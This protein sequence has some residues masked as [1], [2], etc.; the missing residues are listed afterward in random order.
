M[1]FRRTVL[2]VARS[3]RLRSLV[4]GSGVTRGVVNR[5]VAGEDADSVVAAVRDLTGRG[6]LASIDHL[7]EDTLHPEQATGVTRGYVRLLERLAEEGLTPAAEV[8]VKPTAVGLGL[9]AEGESLAAANIARICAAARDAGTTVTVD[10]EAEDA[11]PAT[12]RI[13]NGLRGDFP[14]LGCVLQSYLRR[15]EGDLAAM[16]RPGARIRL[17]KGAYAPDPGSAH[18]DR[19]DV[20]AAYVRALR[21]LMTGPALPMVAT[22]DPRLIEI[23]G[24]LAALA[25]R[26]TE[27]FEYQMLYGVRPDEQLRLVDL[28]A[29]VRVYVPY[30]RDWYGYLA[31]RLAERPANLAFAARSLVSRS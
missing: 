8:S 14:W 4:S 27:E 13:V 7:G 11:V 1:V 20:D 2:S 10:M 16:A 21:R 17:C 5:F 26:S 18:T 30:G 28:G 25:H 29:R 22:H 24:T 12:L 3:D 15:T 19:R 9:G 31:R 23:A 6:L